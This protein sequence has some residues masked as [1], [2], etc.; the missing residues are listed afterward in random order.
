MDDRNAIFREEI[1]MQIIKS[2]K[3]NVKGY[4]CAPSVLA[5]AAAMG[6]MVVAVFVVLWYNEFLTEPLILVTIGPIEVGGCLAYSGLSAWTSMFICTRT[7]WSARVHS[8]K[9][10]FCTMIAVWSE[11][12]MQRRR[13]QPTGGFI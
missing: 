6:V 4:A 13:D 8:A 11:W 10:L 1:I 12:I 9:V 7:I 3:E 2:K 5:G